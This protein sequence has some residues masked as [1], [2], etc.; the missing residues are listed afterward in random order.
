MNNVDDFSQEIERFSSRVTGLLQST[1]SEP[2]SQQELTAEAF[3]E[4]K[5]TLEELKIAS[6]ELQA[7]RMV[8]EKER[9]RY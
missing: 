4:L 2:D 8:V 5:I 7:T 3:E 9:Q 6:D 1:G